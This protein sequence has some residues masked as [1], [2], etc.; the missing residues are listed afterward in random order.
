VTGSGEQIGTG[1]GGFTALLAPRDWDGDGQ[2]D[3]LARTSAGALLL[4]RGNGAGGFLQPT[5]KQIGS[6][7]QVFTALL[8][9]FD[10]SGDG[11]PT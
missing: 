6:G 8:A 9:P 7:W 2:P 5:A 4:Y 10:F 11:N 1:W 3:L